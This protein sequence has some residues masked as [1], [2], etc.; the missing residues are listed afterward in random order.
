MIMVGS[1]AQER[2]AALAIDSLRTFGGR[3]AAEAPVYILLADPQSAP[4][5]LLE[6]KGARTLK[7]NV[8]ARFRGYPFADKV[9]ACAQAEA[10]AGSQADLLVWIT[11]E[12]LI[13]GPLRDLDMPPSAGAALRPVHIQNVGLAAGAAPDPFWA[14]VFQAAG[15]S[16]DQAF[17]VESFADGKQIRAYFNSGV[18]A[19]RPQR[20]LMRAWKEVFEKLLLDQ[21]FQAKACRDQTHRIFL[22]QAVFSALLAGRLG[23]AQIRLLPPTYSYPLHLHESVPAEQRAKT[24]NSLVHIMNEG[25]LRDRGWT[26][27]LAVEEPLR[28]WLLERIAGEPLPVTQ[29]V[30]RSEGSC[31]SYLVETADGDVLIDAGSTAS[32]SSPLLAMN[33]KPVKAVLLTHGHSDHVTHIAAWR[34]KGVPVVAQDEYAEFKHYERRLAGFLDRRFAIQFGAPEPAPRPWAGDYGA[35]IEPNVWFARDYTLES[36]GVHFHVFH[37]GGETPDQSVIWVPERKAVFIGDNF[38]TSFP[39]MYTLRGTK[40][41]WAL[42]YVRALD[43]AIELRPELL[44]PGHG[45]PVRGA[46]EAAKRLTRYRDAILYVHD[47]TVRGM[48]EGKD[49]YALMREIKL[50]EE[51]AVGESYG[52]VAWSVRGVYEGYAGWFD[53]D[54]AHMYAESAESVYPELVKLA[55][56]PEAIGRRALA[57]AESGEALRAL[58]LSD[59]VLKGDPAQPEALSARLKALESLRQSSGNSIENGWLD[60]SIRAARAALRL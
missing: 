10:L 13:V 52:K 50:P 28:K 48:N 23:P 21:E 12:S 54:P 36:G 7:V 24:L 42:D 30:F 22:H 57:L 25:T 59:V 6:A 41:R 29:G 32:P 56:G 8:D 15:V 3:D 46:A 1:P 44:L 11:P 14:G 17:P 35:R 43:K 53:G 49:A 4:G 16:A 18:F 26:R 40:P 39:N 37:T 5:A 9:S 60:H 47:A 2:D 34:E 19:V 51:L 27:R 45:E 38:Y 33:A 31:N 55:G 20:G 58:H